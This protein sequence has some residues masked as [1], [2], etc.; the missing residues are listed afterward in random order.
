MGKALIVVDLQNEFLDSVLGSFATRHIP[1][2]ILL[3]NCQKAIQEHRLDKENTVVWLTSNYENK[4]E[5][6]SN[7]QKEY[8]DWNDSEALE[9]KLE[10]ILHGT[11]VGKRDCCVKGSE[12]SRLHPQMAQLVEEGD[13]SM[14]KGHYSAFNSTNL[15]EKLK[16]KQVEEIT[17]IGVATNFCILA[18][19]LAGKRLGY[20]VNVIQDCVSAK[21]SKYNKQALE[22]LKEKGVELKRLTYGSGDTYVFYD[23]L[24]LD[25]SETIFEDAKNSFQWNTMNHK[26]GEVPRLMAVQAKIVDGKIPIYRHPA[27]EQPETVEFHPITENIC[28]ETKKVVGHD[29]NHALIQLYRNSLDFIGEHSDKTLDV[30]PSTYIM[31]YSA[32]ATRMM[33]LRSKKRSEDGENGQRSVTERIELPHNSLF[34]LGLK[35]NAE[36]THSIRQDKRL[37]REKM[38]DELVYGGQRISWT[39]RSIGTFSKDDKLV[40]LGAKKEE[41]KSETQEEETLELLK[42]FSQE[43]SDP[44]F[45][46]EEHYNRGFNVMNMSRVVPNK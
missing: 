41:F 28:E 46:R 7:K 21:T 14:L 43:N 13:I 30:N 37:Q 16:E 24:D 11:H 26:G 35:T 12:A 19:C 31:N 34:V 23:F 18:T 22:V 27:D 20:R 36:F 4:E 5:S 3:N 1:A 25:R 33:I 38:P 45:K 6:R 39:L 9:E 17:V 44:N 2:R 32:G 8:Q 40:G 42:A 15:H 29:L 10:W